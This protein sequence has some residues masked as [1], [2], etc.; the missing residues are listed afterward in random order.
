MYRTIVIA[1]DGSEGSDRALPVAAAYAKRDGARV[2]VAHARTHALETAIEEKLWAQVEMLQAD[3]I[4]CSLSIKDGLY[5][6]EAE[7]IAG[8]AA[9][10]EADLIVI[11]S[12]GRGPFK[13][14]VL[15]SVTQRLLPIA[16]CPVLV[17][18]GG[19]ASATAG[20]AVATA[21]Q[22]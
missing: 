22:A 2:V 18:P 1:L 15:G 3:G 6:D 20:S 19:Y 13:G 21:A 4:A 17:V 10:A 14:A 7:E 16:S 9:D 12:R 11:A 8:I 5:G